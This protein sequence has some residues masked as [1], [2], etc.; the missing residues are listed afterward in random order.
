MSDR[1]GTDC[2]NAMQLPWSSHETDGTFP[3]EPGRLTDFHDA[4]PLVVAIIP[5][6]PRTQSVTEAQ[7]IDCQASLGGPSFVGT[8]GVVTAV[9]LLPPST[10]RSTPLPVGIQHSLLSG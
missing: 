5:G 7:P 4:P 8:E 1:D 2:A 10:V 6:P 3:T 9:Q